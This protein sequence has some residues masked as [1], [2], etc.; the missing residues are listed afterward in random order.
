MSI[1]LLLCFGCSSVLDI[2]DGSRQSLLLQ[3]VMNCGR[4]SSHSHRMLSL[5][6]MGCALLC[7]HTSGYA[8]ALMMLSEEIL[9]KSTAS[10]ISSSECLETV[11]NKAHLH[12]HWQ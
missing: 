7:V 11:F 6:M 4:N 9:F 12:Q 2:S 8:A 5:K 3:Q 1:L 10:V